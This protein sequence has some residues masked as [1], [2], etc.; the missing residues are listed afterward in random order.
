[1]VKGNLFVWYSI[2]CEMQCMTASCNA[3]HRWTTTACSGMTLL[4]TPL[5]LLLVLPV[6]TTLSLS[7]TQKKL[8]AS[9]LR[10]RLGKPTAF[11]FSINCIA[12]FQMPY[13]PDE[14]DFENC[15]L[16]HC[17]SNWCEISV[18][19][20]LAEFRSEWLLS[21]AVDVWRHQSRGTIRCDRF[22]K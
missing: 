21:G 4:Y 18:Y 10:L 14:N 16:I 11:A 20:P 7:I 6:Y 19:N 3:V 8:V 9:C 13:K 17:E 15:A 1:M 22:I 12:V 5:L 2:T